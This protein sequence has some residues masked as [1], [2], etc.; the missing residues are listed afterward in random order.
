MREGWCWSS[1]RAS[2]VDIPLRGMTVSDHGLLML[3]HR[4]RELVLSAA[5]LGDEEQVRG[6]GRVERGGQRLRAGIGDWP[7]RQPGVLIRVVGIRTGQIG[8]VNRSA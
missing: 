6:I 5:G 7:R 2:S 8:L 4:S 3:R 1:Q